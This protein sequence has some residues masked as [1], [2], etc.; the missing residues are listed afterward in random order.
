MKHLYTCNILKHPYIKNENDVRNLIQV[1]NNTKSWIVNP[2]ESY[3]IR[4]T[5][6]NSWVWDKMTRNTI[7]V[8]GRLYDNEWIKKFNNNEIKC[9]N[10]YNIDKNPN[11]GFLMIDNTLWGLC[12]FD[13]NIKARKLKLLK[14][15][16]HIL[17]EI[18]NE[19]GFE[20]KQQKIIYNTL[21][22]VDKE[23]VENNLQN[24]VK[25]ILNNSNEVIVNFDD[26]LKIPIY[27]ST[28]N[29]IQNTQDE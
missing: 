17:E 25:H 18:G 6:S 22:Y 23:N 14:T 29:N 16:D 11:K 28:N 9:N 12:Q 2:G 3:V 21:Y 7:D 1:L 4:K 27:I 13:T 5:L 10:F 15:P 8:G 26:S 19:I 24:I 20:S